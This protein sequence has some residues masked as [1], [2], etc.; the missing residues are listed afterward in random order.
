MLYLNIRRFGLVMAIGIALGFFPGQLYAII[1]NPGGPM[2]HA[3]YWRYYWP[4]TLTLL[5]AAI[6]GLV[7]D[8][9]HRKLNH[10]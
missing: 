1:T 4:L 9:A 2:D 5:A 10:E 7:A 6:F 8:W 3:F